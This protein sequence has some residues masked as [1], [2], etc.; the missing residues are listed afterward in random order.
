MNK[1]SVIFICT[2]NSARSQL[3]EALF[4]HMAIDQF[5]VFSAG[6]APE[7]IDPR[8][9]T[10][11]DARHISGENL[12]SKDLTSLNERYFD[13]AI[14]LCDKAHQS[15]ITQVK[16]AQI[17]AW[18][19]AD[20]KPKAGTKAFDV[21][22]NELS[23]RI[24]YFL[25]F[26]QKYRAKPEQ[27]SDALSFYKALADDTRLKTLLLIQQQQELCVCELTAAL[28]ETQPKISRHLAQLRKAAILQDRRHGQWVFYRLADNLPDWALE[29]LRL[30]AANNSALIADNLSKLNQMGDRPQ[31]A[32]L[33]N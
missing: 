20:P 15:C 23:E 33:C 2:G 6:T 13:Y 32:A 18:D 22:L 14:T 25:L 16:A 21:V 26:S 31:R 3:A 8:V 30:T 4:R 9:F 11:L 24:K 1:K 7:P 10:V 19:F 29:V 12:R 5:D 27:L 28:T 17:L